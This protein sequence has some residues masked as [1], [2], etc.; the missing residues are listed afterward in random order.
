MKKP[1]VIINGQE[2]DASEVTDSNGLLDKEMIELIQLEQQHNSKS[3]QKQPQIAQISFSGIEGLSDLPPEVQQKLQNLQ[4]LMPELLSGN[5]L[6]I[7]KNLGKLQKAGSAFLQVQNQ[8]NQHMMEGQS[9]NSAN[10]QPATIISAINQPT[11]SLMNNNQS[12]GS[13]EKT[14][15]NSS[16]S[17]ASTTTS[18]DSAQPNAQPFRSTSYNSG[19]YHP[20]SIYKGS[21]GDGWRKIILIGALVLIGYLVYEYVFNRQL[22]F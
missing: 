16:N 5:P 14:K 7:F 21:S 1:K 8:I 3:G 19:T 10:N 18:F 22:P 12:G 20:P 4:Q 13:S 6:D 9:T 17:S 11:S 15:Y 2:F